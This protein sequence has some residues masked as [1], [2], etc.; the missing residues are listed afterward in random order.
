MLNP[1]FLRFPNR[2]KRI[3]KTDKRISP[4]LIGQKTGHPPPHRLPANRQ[5]PS[6]MTSHFSEHFAPA[7][8]QF[9]RRIRRAFTAINPP[10]RHIRK[11]KPQHVH[12]QSSKAPSHIRHPVTVHRRTRP[13]GQDQ[14]RRSLARRS[15]PKPPMIPHALR[16]LIPV[17]TGL[18]LFV[19]ACLAFSL[20]ITPGEG[21][22]AFSARAHFG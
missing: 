10:L 18:V 12:A 7:L 20:P 13:M 4:Q 11:L 9:R 15:I 14:C 16:P 6:D 3:S 2:I 1:R 22:A 8:K 21:F 19:H 5:N 17:N